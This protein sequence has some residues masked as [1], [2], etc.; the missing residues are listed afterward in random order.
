MAK[1]ITCACGYIFS[2]ETDDELWTKAQ[3]HIKSAHPE[4]VGKV[5]RDDILGQAELI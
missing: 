5:Q 2:G 3:D 4:M 1:Q